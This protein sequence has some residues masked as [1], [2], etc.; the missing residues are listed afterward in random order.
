[1]KIQVTSVGSSSTPQLYKIE[2]YIAEVNRR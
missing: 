1:M 2:I